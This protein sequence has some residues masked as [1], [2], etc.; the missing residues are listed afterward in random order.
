MVM[1]R[2]WVHFIWLLSKI[3][4]SWHPQ[5]VS[6][7]TTLQNLQG[8][9]VLLVWLE[10]LFL[11]RLRLEPLTSNQT[12]IQQRRSL[13]WRRKQPIY[14]FRFQRAGAH[15]PT[16]PPLKIYLVAVFSSPEPLD[17]QGELIGWPWS[18]VR[19]SVVRPSVHNFKDLLLWNRLANQ[20][21]ILYE[22]SIV[23][24]ELIWP[25]LH[26]PPRTIFHGCQIVHWDPRTAKNFCPQR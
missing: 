19:P 23:P 3:R 25:T 17:S 15:I 5:N 26:P 6:N 16:R 12:V 2:L 11:G 21:Q 13:A 10:P 18:G 24:R 14:F 8:L 22:A 9:Y 7:I 1:W 4:T 20:S